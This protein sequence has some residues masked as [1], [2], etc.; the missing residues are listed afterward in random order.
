MR[1]AGK[2]LFLE[3]FRFKFPYI[4]TKNSY[5]FL[6]VNEGIFEII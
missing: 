4:D 2:S 1:K 6:M 5:L 3:I